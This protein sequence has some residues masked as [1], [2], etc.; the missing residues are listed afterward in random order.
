VTRHDGLSPRGWRVYNGVGVVKQVAQ[1]C[2]LTLRLV[3]FCDVSVVPVG[4]L[5]SLFFRHVQPAA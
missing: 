3:I 5:G 2:F 1:S 4:A